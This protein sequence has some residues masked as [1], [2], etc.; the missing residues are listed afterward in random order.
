M[1]KYGRKEICNEDEGS[2]QLDTQVILQSSDKYF[3]PKLKDK[4]KKI[5]RR[6]SKRYYIYSSRNKDSRIGDKSP[7]STISKRVHM[8]SVSFVAKPATCPTKTNYQNFDT[9]SFD[10]GIDS[11]ATRCISND[12]N[13]FQGP[14]IPMQQK[15]CKGFGGAKTPIA[16]QGTIK[17]KLLDDDGIQ[18]T[19]LIKKALFIPK[20]TMC[21]LSPQHVDKSL[22]DASNGSHRL[23]ESTDSKGSVI[24]LTK[25]NREYKKTVYHNV[26]TNTPV[27]MSAPDNSTFNSY[28]ME[29]KE[30][31]NS[32]E[33]EVT[34][35]AGE[36]I[37]RK[38]IH[39]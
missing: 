35:F 32:E 12:I 25:G 7:R 26:R 29:C 18:H 34:V 33:L 10:I 21:L 14:I 24:Q 36:I 22:R 13:H 8:P 15:S 6:K 9:G 37:E 28:C 1:D 16:G 19:L 38:E 20:A 39:L 23:K 5:R 11:H 2:F 4:S 3:K 17:W 31:T 30:E 27:F